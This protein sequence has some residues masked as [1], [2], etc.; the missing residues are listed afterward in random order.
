MVGPGLFEYIINSSSNASLISVTVT[1]NQGTYYNNLAV[2]A[3]AITVCGPTLTFPN[4]GES[5]IEYATG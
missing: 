5:S 2:G 1:L 4:L 3:H